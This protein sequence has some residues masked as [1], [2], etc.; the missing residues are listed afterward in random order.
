MALA[1]R[2]YGEGEAIPPIVSGDVIRVPF[3]GSAFSVTTEDFVPPGYADEIIRRKLI[4]VSGSQ[5][6]ESYLY[7]VLERIGA[8]CNETDL[9]YAEQ[10]IG[11]AKHLDRQVGQYRFF[12]DS[13]IS[14]EQLL[15]QAHQNPPGQVILENL[16]KITSP[17]FMSDNLAYYE[18]S[19]ALRTLASVRDDIGR[20]SAGITSTA[21]YHARLAVLFEHGVLKSPEDI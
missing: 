21:L 11:D 7:A 20:T 8:V 1:Q 12:R 13:G 17:D 18:E 3:G 15:L 4:A 14:H 16:G 5:D 10:L 19:D 2:E 9:D 6:W